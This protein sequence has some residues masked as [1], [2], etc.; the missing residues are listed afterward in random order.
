[1]GSI[2]VAM[3]E[4]GVCAIALGDDPDALTRDLLDRFPEAER[5]GGNRELEKYV[6]A[7]ID[8]IEMPALGL[9]LPLDVRG[10]AFQQKVWQALR[11]IPAGTKISYSEI[12]ECIGSPKAVRAVATACAANT[13]AVA[14]PCH[15]VVRSD[16]SLSG[17]RWGVERKAE[18]LRRESK[19]STPGI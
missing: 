16:G 11:Q 2:L 10:T 15:R 19:T 5:I 18:L 3:S 14:I 4:R 1:M 17:Y 7:V 13:L 9:D 8:F 12:A 6:A